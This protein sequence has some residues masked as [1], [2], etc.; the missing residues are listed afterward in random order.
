MGYRAS[1]SQWRKRRASAKLFKS[2]LTFEGEDSAMDS[3]RL[4]MP[5]WVALLVVLAAAAA[6]RI[7]YV[8]AGILWHSP[9]KDRVQLP[10]WQSHRAADGRDDRHTDQ[11]VENL[12]THRWFGGFAPLSDVEERTAHIS[13]GYPWLLS[14]AAQTTEDWKPLVRWIQAGLG[15]MTAGMY[16]LFA[17]RAFR[18]LLVA[19]LTGLFCAV[20]PFWVVNCDEIADGTLAT[21]LLSAC[22]LLGMHAGQVGGPTASLLFGVGLAALSLVRAALLPFAVVTLLWFL[23]RCR[24]LKRGWLFALLAFLGF[25]NGLVPWTLRNYQAFGDVLPIVDSTYLHLWIGNHPGADGGTLSQLEVAEVLQDN[26]RDLS[27]AENP[28][29][30]DDRAEVE[31][32]A[33]WKQ[34]NQKERY[35]NLGEVVVKNIQLDPAGAVKRRISAG[36]C[37]VFGSSWDSQL[38]APKMSVSSENERSGIFAGSLLALLILAILGWRWTYLY[39]KTSMPLSLA[40]I[41]IPLPYILSH[42]EALSGPRLPLDGVLLCYAAFALACLIPGYG[43]DLF[44]GPEAKAE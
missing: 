38:H 44:R 14:L 43:R 22:L 27:F 19:T 30:R 36:L 41:W 39:Q 16:F 31:V 7:W 42:A 15:T 11:L 24:W 9:D 40:L 8:G 1:S 13:P 34:L 35:D 12:K 10:D 21:F 18:S 25:V 20:Y 26:L 4:K 33:R 2:S 17:R 28:T 23:L 5:D 37:F 29:K 32:I 3:R 6:A